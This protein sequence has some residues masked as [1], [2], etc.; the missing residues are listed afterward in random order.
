[1]GQLA[2]SAGPTYHLARS[3]RGSAKPFFLYVA[4]QTVHEPLEVSHGPLSHS[5][6]TLYRS[7]VIL[8][9]KFTQG[10]AQMTPRPHGYSRC[11]TST[12]RRITTVRGGPTCRASPPRPTVRWPRRSTA[13]RA[14]GRARSPCRF[15]C[16]AAH[17]L[18][19]R[20]HAPPAGCDA[21]GHERIRC[22]C[23]FLKLQC[24]RRTLV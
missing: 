19:T 13:R 23:C 4:F 24:D 2:L 18:H 7:S 8:Y 20:V 11:P 22:L 6:T 21:V 12:A 5:C 14:R 3:Q 15:V 10:G 9:S 1:M 16:T 17:P